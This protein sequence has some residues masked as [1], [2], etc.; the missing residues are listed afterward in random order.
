MELDYRSDHLPTLLRFQ[1][2]VAR[3]ESRRYRCWKKLDLKK[4]KVY[5]AGLDMSRPINIADKLEDYSC[6]LSSYI[7]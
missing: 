3:P 1:L 7:L 2:E 6:Y 5:I 4:A